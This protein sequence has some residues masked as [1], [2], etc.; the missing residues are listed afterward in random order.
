MQKLKDDG[1]AAD[2]LDA[3]GFYR[4]LKKMEKDGYLTSESEGKGPKARKTFT[5]T[6]FGRQALKSWEDSLRKY[7]NHISHIVDGISGSSR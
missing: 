7:S 5:I 6:D 2:N 4:N 1:Y 3:T